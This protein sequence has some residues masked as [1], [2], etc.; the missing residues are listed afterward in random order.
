VYPSHQMP[1]QE[2]VRTYEGGKLFGQPKEDEH[3]L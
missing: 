1:E 3:E 2:P